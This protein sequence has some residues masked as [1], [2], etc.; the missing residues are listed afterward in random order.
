MKQTTNLKSHDLFRLRKHAGI[1]LSEAESKLLGIINEA[2]ID[3]RYPGELGLLPNGKPTLHEAS[4][5]VKLA[6]T[7]FNRIKKSLEHS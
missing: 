4:E 3:S 2:Y 6:E 7:I 5:F 1:I